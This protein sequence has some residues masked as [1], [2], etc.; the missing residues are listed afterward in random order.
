M[1]NDKKLL[2]LSYYFLSNTNNKKSFVKENIEILKNILK[3]HN[4]KYYLH[5]DPIISDYEYDK[6]FFKLKQWE[7]LYPEFLD[8]NS[9]TQR[10][11]IQTQKQLKKVAHEIPLLSLEN[12]YSKVGLLDFDKKNKKNLNINKDL[13]YFVSFKYD[14]LTLKLTYENGILK[15]AST[16]GNGFIGEDVTLNSMVIKNIPKKIDTDEKLLIIRGE[17]IMSKKDFIELNKK[18]QKKGL[19]L[20][21]NARNAASG[22][23]RQLDIS[24]TKSR[25]LSFCPFYILNCDNLNLINHTDIYLLLKKYQFDIGKYYVCNNINEV[26]N[27]LD[28]VEKIRSNLDF[29]IDGVVVNINNLKYNQFLG[30]TSHHP[31][32]AI[33]YKFK[34]EIGITQIID[35]IF[36]VGKT[37]NVTP[38]AILKPVSVSG[39]IVTRATLHNMKFIKDKDIKINDFVYI[40]RAGEVIPEVVKVEIEKRDNTQKDILFPSVC[41]SCNTKLLNNNGILSCPNLNCKDIL[42][43]Q[44]IY[45]VSKDAMNIENLGDKLIK[46]M[47]DFGMIQSYVDIYKLKKEDLFKIDNIKDVMA[48]KI[49]NNINKSKTTDLWRLISGLNIKNVGVENAKNLANY[50]KNISRLYYINFEDLE[51]IEDIGPI[52]AKNISDYFNDEINIQNIKELLSLGI[53]IKNIQTKSS[54]FSGV[55]FVITGILENFS[56]EKLKEI[57]ENE[58]GKVLSSVSKNVNY[59]IVGKNPGSK[60]DKAI[61]LGVQILYEEDFINLYKAV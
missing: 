39:V 61:K 42:E 16:R 19:K 40:K 36:Q 52:I 18:N 13:E 20:F 35:V 26:C 5:S 29:D 11:I 44:L 6:L 32:W 27:I 56:R 49:I 38:V 31:K 10:L 37:G 23:L 55:S 4:I 43:K 8:K 45:F 58:G 7:D 22:S 54:K 33:A 60:E 50:F 9:P 12:V 25:N 14:G 1:L 30:Q 28:E 3:E 15:N 41:P 34:E 2:E 59:L 17:V 48:Q 46:K 51:K 47:L 57:I 24:I 53:K 21:A